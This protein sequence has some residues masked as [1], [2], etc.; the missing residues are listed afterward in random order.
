MLGSYGKAFGQLGDSR[1]ILP[2]LYTFG[3][4]LLTAPIAFSLCYIGF[5]WLTDAFLAWL[6]DGD[7]W[8]KTTI[9]WV[10]RILGF[11]IVLVILFFAFGS[12]QTAYLCFFMDGVIEAAC[13]RQD[14]PIEL[15]PPPSF[16]RSCW[17]AIRFLAL[18]ILVNA[19]VL[20]LVLIGWILPPL[21][22]IVQLLAN[23]YLLGWELED[24]V[25]TRFQSRPRISILKRSL[26][27]TIAASLFLIPFLN[28]LA[29]VLSATAFTHY[30]ASKT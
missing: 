5:D 4:A 19:L 13:D 22:I 12:I 21:G 2:L 8:W 30:V 7:S 6:W 16:E 29:P 9:E 20:P 23:G 10:L 14:P 15:N 17:S 3:L 11:F 27:G 1:L 26:F 25:S 28:L 18:L 24:L